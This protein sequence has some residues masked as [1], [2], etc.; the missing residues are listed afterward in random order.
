MTFLNNLPQGS[1]F[2]DGVRGGPTYSGYYIPGGQPNPIQP[3]Y[4]PPTFVPAN[5]EKWG[6]GIQYSPQQTYR[7]TPYLSSSGNIVTSQ[8]INQGDL[9]L[10]GGLSSSINQATR[11]ITLKGQTAIQF[12]WPRGIS[13]TVGVGGVPAGGGVKI[14]VFGNDVYGIPM[15]KTFTLAGAA[16][17]GTYF[18]SYKTDSQK[19]FYQVTRVA[20]SAVVPNGLSIQANE[21]FGMP[22]KIG[23]WST[24]T[25]FNWAGQNM[26]DQYGFVLAGAGTGL[27]T[28]NTPAIGS[29]SAFVPS[30]PVFAT[31]NVNSATNVQ[32]SVNMYNAINYTSFQLASSSPTAIGL[33]WRIQDGGQNLFQFADE[34]TP[35]TTT[36]DVRGMFALPT[37]ASADG[38]NTGSLWPASGANFNLQYAPPTINASLNAI[39]TSYIFGSDN[40]QNQL[41]SA[42]QPIG[43]FNDELTVPYLQGSDLL[44]LPQFYSGVAS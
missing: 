31:S 1:Y 21:I 22:Y 4:T 32:N 15:Q 39:I 44:G 25:G 37:I 11:P 41:A 36:G 10:G 38:T 29:V 33:A 30:N 12:D 2:G 7:I 28:I 20:S 26:R 9:P 16:P 23:N 42:G 40:F 27:A 34:R 14:T 13:I 8:A 43:P 5:F 3:N 17:R 35:S 18:T 19:A 6:N 24:I